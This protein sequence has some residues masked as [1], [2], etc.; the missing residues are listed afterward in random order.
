MEWIT[1]LVPNIELWF[2]FGL[3]MALGGL[4]GLEREYAQQHVA[5]VERTF[6]GIRTFPLISL[7]GALSAFVATQLQS[8][9]VF[10]VAFG[11]MAVLVGITYVRRLTDERGDRSEGITTEV[12]I[13]LVFM[14]GSLTYWGWGTLASAITVVVTLLLSLKRTLHDMA[15]RLTQEDLLAT[16]Q[17]ALITAVVL[18]ILPNRPLDPYGVINLYR[19]WLL[20]VLISGVSFGGYVAIKALGPHRALW[21]TGLLGGV[22]SS[23]ATTLSLAAR[24]HS[25]P[26]LAPAFGVALILASTV[27]Y[28]R[29]AV[30]LFIVQPQ[31][32]WT[33]LPY[34][35]GLTVIGLM[36]CYVLWQFYRLPTEERGMVLE[37]PLNLTGAIRFALIFVVVSFIVQFAQQYLGT[38]GLF[39]ASFLTGLMG[40]DAIVLSLAN[41]TATGGLS[42]M[43]AT[44]A[45][46]IATLGNT[47]AKGVLAYTLGATPIRKPATYG[48]G[49]LTVVG[50][51]AVLTALRFSAFIQ[52]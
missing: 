10:A 32:F 5:D 46:I 38:F 29:V 30:L 18:P 19:I 27:M 50:V 23:T 14:L 13:L 2:R 34:L 41:A 35:V 8:P 42:V 31:L 28:P 17:F 1:S 39:A 26:R 40:V 15:R 44:A 48:F 9:T 33:T 49:V 43:N 51:I 12:T 4:V 25:S 16:L 22:V 47:V 36:T 24:S 45:V 7:L 20:V 6:A 3:A 52:G 11:G 37:N 21:L